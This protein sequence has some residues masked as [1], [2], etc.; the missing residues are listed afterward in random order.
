MQFSRPQTD[1][2]LGLQK[3]SSPENYEFRSPQHYPK[4]KPHSEEINLHRSEDYAQEQYVCKSRNEFL[5]WTLALFLFPLSTFK[6]S[7]SL[8]FSL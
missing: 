4:K 5:A 8:N 6:P 3:D 1:S 7:Y 2:G